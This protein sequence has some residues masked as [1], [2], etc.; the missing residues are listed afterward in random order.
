MASTARPA[1]VMRSASS[2]SGS[3]MSTY[4]FSQASGANMRSSPSLQNLRVDSICRLCQL[5]VHQVHRQCSPLAP[6]MTVADQVAQIVGDIA[7][8]AGQHGMKRRNLIVALTDRLCKIG[9]Q[10]EDITCKMSY[11]VCIGEVIGDQAQKLL[12]STAEAGLFCDL[13]PER[14]LYAFCR[15][16]TARE[17]AVDTCRVVRLGMQPDLPGGV[18]NRK[19]DFGAAVAGGLP[20]IGT[21][22]LVCLDP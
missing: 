2:F 4:S 8:L 22:V 11:F 15:V 13:A 9:T 1:S 18:L 17:Q 6:A 14:L 20:S 5:F 10:S 3:V 16:H 7:Q 12:D 19:H 21:N